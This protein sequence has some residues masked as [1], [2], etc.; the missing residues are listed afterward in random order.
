[1]KTA[2]PGV[3]TTA[4]NGIGQGAIL[5]SDYTANSSAYAA[6]AGSTVMIYMAGLGVPTSTGLN[7]ASAT[8]AAFPKSCISPTAYQ[9]A[10]NGQSGP[11]NPLWT[12]IDGAVIE[13]ALLAHNVFPPCFATA[14][15]VSIGGKAATV[16][17]AGWV[18][19]S[20]GGLYQVNATIPT[21][22]GASNSVPVLVT[23]GGFTSQA[24]V[25]MAVVLSTSLNGH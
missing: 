6:K 24:G 8:A 15:T 11:P 22:V 18:A 19:G 2:D 21:T 4:A 23:A 20:V 25:T 17:Y 14:P 16:T 7:Q 5:N 1:V 3:F 9:A 12:K 13:S 10:V